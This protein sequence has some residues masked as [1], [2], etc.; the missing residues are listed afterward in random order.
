VLQFHCGISYRN[1]MVWRNAGTL[2]VTTTP[3]HD[4]HGQPIDRHMPTGPDC[5][6]IRDLMIR[7]QRSWRTMRSITFVGSGENPA[8]SIWLWARARFRNCRNS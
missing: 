2:D 7:S 3:R 6:R 4:I 5:E 8:T 1:L